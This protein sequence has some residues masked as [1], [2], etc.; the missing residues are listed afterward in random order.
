MGDPYVG[1]IADFVVDV[2]QCRCD[3]TNEKFHPHLATFF[4]RF[5]VD[6]P[7]GQP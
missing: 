7:L 5:A 1:K 4:W 2:R 6:A 3:A